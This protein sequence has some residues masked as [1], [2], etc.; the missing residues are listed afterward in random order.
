M[1]ELKELELCEINS[2]GDLKDSLAKNE[3]CRNIVFNSKVPQI[4]KEVPCR[5][6]VDEAGRGPVLGKFDWI[7]TKT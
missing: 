2:I 7:I 1:G 4:C 6:G 3:N 5:L